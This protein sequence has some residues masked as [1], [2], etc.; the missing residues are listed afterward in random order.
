M[1]GRS[2]AAGVV[3]VFI[4]ILSSL[5]LY[6]HIDEFPLA[7]QYVEGAIK[8]IHEG[9]WQDAETIL[10]RGYDFASVSSDLSYLMA[11]VRLQLARPIGSVLESIRQARMTDRW[12]RY[13]AESASFLEAQALIVLRQF[14]QAQQI[15]KSITT[16]AD[17]VYLQLKILA[18]R[19]AQ[20]EFSQLFSKAVQLY[21]LDPRFAAL[22]FS[23]MKD[24]VPSTQD[25][26]II[27]LLL[28]RL[29]AL[30]KADPFLPILA[31]P[32]IQD[33]A[34]KRRILEAYRALGNDMLPV[35]SLA[36]DL[37]VIDEKNAILELFRH[38][39]LEVELVRRVWSLLRTDE[40]RQIFSQQLSVFSGIMTE[41]SDSDGIP[42]I[43]VSYING[44]INSYQ[45]DAN[46]DR[47]HEIRV[48]FEQGFPKEG[49]IA[50]FEGTLDVQVFWD[51]YPTVEKFTAGDLTYI[52]APSSFNYAPFT[53]K[54]LVG[55]YPDVSVLFP[56]REFFIPRLTE[57]ALISFAAKIIR[58]GTIANDAIETIEL[59][60]GIPLRAVETR[61]GRIVSILEFSLGKP[62][63]QRL[64]MDLDGRMETIRRFPST[65]G[66][67]DSLNGLDY[68][69]KFDV[70]ESDWDGDGIYEYKERVR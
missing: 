21:P 64:D 47:T 8:A 27:P 4:N 12:H 39:T 25:T 41:D 54:A 26:K 37:G 44:K 42:E 58:P 17:V 23:Y 67:T 7:Q 40:S 11:L 16:T 1:R 61:K 18:L 51:S 49:Y 9:R 28:N 63:L 46:Q 6:A 59:S 69:N 35:L 29:A 62:I 3:I 10:E 53:L 50:P 22:Y 33:T 56:E 24:K 32:F 48:L 36:L 31:I 20:G 52:P 30:Q 19:N 2:I 57:R 14:D 45:Y 55:S 15:L 13:T 34:E 60:N 38:K 43:E 70:V 5:P 66:I 65:I 68:R